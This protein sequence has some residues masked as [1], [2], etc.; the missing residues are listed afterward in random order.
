[1]RSWQRGPRHACTAY[2]LSAKARPP[3]GPTLRGRDEECPSRDRSMTVRYRVDPMA[4]Q[5][6]PAVVEIEQS[7]FLTPWPA[8]AYLREIEQNALARYIV[9]RE[10]VLPER[11]EIEASTKHA[12][13]PP[14]SRIG[15]VLPGL[16]RRLRSLIEPGRLGEPSPKG[17]DS[18]HR[19][20]SD[21]EGNARIVGYAGLW[22]MIDEAHVTSVAVHPSARGR[23]LGTLL[24]LGMFAIGDEMGARWL[25]LEVRVSNRVARA[26]YTRLGFREAGI[27]PRY[28]TDNGE[29]AIIMWSDALDS[30]AHLARISALQSRWASQ[31]D[32]ASPPFA[33]SR[34]G[35]GSH[36]GARMRARGDD[37]VR[38]RVAPHFLDRSRLVLGDG[39]LSG[40][41]SCCTGRYGLGGRLWS[42]WWG[43]V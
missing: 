43:R 5:D 37:S 11:P 12:S 6:V 3:S 10:V 30:E 2:A 19:R 26:M 8:G 1:M 21:A 40:G 32:G 24:M 7:S 28:Y 33:R 35:G 41:V 18:R 16:G 22:L 27:R 29:D 4:L 31:V 25:T 34:G 15:S 38:T 14:L 39:A 13:G 20:P 9:V 17:D 42:G 36:H 23:G